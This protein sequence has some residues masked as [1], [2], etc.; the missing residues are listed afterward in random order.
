METRENGAHSLRLRASGF[1][2][3]C[4]WARV[5]PVSKTYEMTVS[6]TR[7]DNVETVTGTF[8]EQNDGVTVL[9]LGTS[10]NRKPA[11]VV[12]IRAVVDNIVIRA[13]D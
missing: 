3:R 5:D 2:S 13:A 4:H 8:P 9:H 11:H 6:G 7:P 1:S 12:M 10:L